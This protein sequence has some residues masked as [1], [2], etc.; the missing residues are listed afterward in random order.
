MMKG[1]F[2]STAERAIELQSAMTGLKGVMDDLK[3]STH[4]FIEKSGF[5]KFLGNLMQG[6]VKQIGGAKAEDWINF[7]YQ[8]PEG[9]G[10]FDPLAPMIGEPGVRYYKFSGTV[11]SKLT[12]NPASS[13]GFMEWRRNHLVPVEPS[14]ANNFARWELS[15]PADNV[16]KSTTLNVSTNRHYVF[17]AVWG[18]PAPVLVKVRLAYGSEENVS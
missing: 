17:T 6:F 1:Y 7:F 18:S 12:A 16:G 9:G 14:M 10:G 5:D 3:T 4:E 8:P 11:A 15:T 2:S 13:L